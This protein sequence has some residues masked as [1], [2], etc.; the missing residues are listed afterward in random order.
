VT[1]QENNSKNKDEVS[2]VDLIIEP[3]GYVSRSYANNYTPNQN[4]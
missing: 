3:D 4:N 1:L 2:F